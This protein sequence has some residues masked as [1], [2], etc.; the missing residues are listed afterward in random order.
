MIE[1]RREM[2]EAKKANK[3]R[4]KRRRNSSRSRSK[5][6]KKWR[7]EELMKI[8]MNLS[9]SSSPL[10]STSSQIYLYL[11]LLSLARVAKD[12]A[13]TAHRSPDLDHFTL[14]DLAEQP[15]GES[16][17]DDSDEQWWTADS[18]CWPALVCR[19]IGNCVTQW[20]TMFVAANT[21]PDLDVYANFV[22]KREKGEVDNRVH[23]TPLYVTWNRVAR[24]KV[25]ARRE[26]VEWSV[27]LAATT[28][29]RYRHR[30]YRNRSR[31]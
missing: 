22:E 15:S 19:L 9:S 17:V 14:A 11:K 13:K 1:K 25:E 3:M 20:S 27:C 30:I 12:K 8:R 7:R 21:D 16:V 29:T 10:S 26:K 5:K 2:I 4:K 24:Q 28:P 31:K 18:E 23:F 6:K